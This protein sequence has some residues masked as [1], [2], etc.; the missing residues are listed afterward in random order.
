MSPKSPLA[1]AP[2][3]RAVLDAVPGPMHPAARETLWAALDDGWAD[4]T[5]LHSESRRARRLLDQAREIL[6]VAVG[7]APA[8]LS[9]LP[10]GTS[11]LLSALD[12]LGH[13]RRRHGRSLV[14]SAVEASAVLTWGQHAAGGEADLAAAGI[15]PVDDVGRVDAEAFATAMGRP[16]VAV[17]ALQHANPE[18]GTVQPVDDCVRAAR[19]SGVPLLVDA[20]ASLGRLPT[21]RDTDVIVGDATSFAGP[22]GVGLLG[23]RPGTRY[24]PPGPTSLLERGRATETPWVPQVL[25]AAEAWRQVN[26]TRAADAAAARDLIARIRATA[27]AIPDVDVAGPDPTLGDDASLPHVLTFSVLYVDGERL[28][29]AFDRHGFAVSSGSACTASVLEPSHVLA[30]MGRLT[31][32]NVRITLPVAAT[33]PDLSADVARFCAVLPE[34]VAQCRAELGVTDL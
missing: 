33:A 16:G 30:A 27:A 34:V 25:A 21:P 6:A 28:V 17:A 11:A 1:P 8:D 26:H 32:G 5:R 14:A 24:L 10:G 18:V 2:P 4:P 3:T 15:V 12:A 7:V 9:F 29:N 22:T 23:V 31:Q 19:E 13:A 20:T